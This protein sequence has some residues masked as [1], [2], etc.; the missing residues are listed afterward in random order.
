M[1]KFVLANG[2]WEKDESDFFSTQISTLKDEESSVV[3]IDIGANCGLITRQILNKIKNPISVVL[4]E[5]VPIHLRALEGNLEMYSKKH[6]IEIVDAA[7]DASKE[8]AEIFVEVNNRGNSS[9]IQE[10]TKNTSYRKEIIKT[11]APSIFSEKF[12]NKNLSIFLKCDIQGFDAK[13]LK[14]MCFWDDV[15]GAIVEIWSHESILEGDVDMALEKFIKLPKWYW[16]NDPKKTVTLEDVKEFWLSKK[17]S[18]K[19]LYMCR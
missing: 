12:E 6:N 15:Y 7:L 10:N 1:Y 2:F 4:V 5:P 9:L 19:N 14:D 3:F 11:L 13:V 18:T 8:S 17:S 16:D